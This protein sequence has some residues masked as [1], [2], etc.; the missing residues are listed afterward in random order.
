MSKKSNPN[1]NCVKQYVQQIKKKS[2]KLS[3]YDIFTFENKNNLLYFRGYA[4][5]Y[6]SPESFTPKLLNGFNIDPLKFD[7]SPLSSYPTLT[8]VQKTII[9]DFDKM[10]SYGTILYKAPCGAGKTKAALEFIYHFKLRTLIISCRNAVNDQWKKEINLTFPKLNVFTSKELK[11]SNSSSCKSSYDILILTPQ[12]ILKHI[13]TITK[14][15]LSIDLIIYDE[16]HSLT[17]LEFS[18]VLS[19]PFKL[20]LKN[21][22]Y[23]PY[24]IGLTASLPTEKP[25]IELLK[26]I[27]GLPKIIKNEKI[28]SIP[29]YYSDYRDTV[30]KRGNYDENYIRPSEHET[31]KLLLQKFNINNHLPSIDFKMIVITKLIESSIY[32]AILSAIMFQKDVLLIR[33]A[34]EYDYIIKYENIPD[35]YY[36][37]IE[38]ESEVN[39][40]NEMNEE[41]YSLETVLKDSSEQ[42]KP[43]IFK[44]KYQD[45][46]NE[47]AII[48]G[49]TDRLKEGF[50]CE[51]IVYGVCSN[52][53]WS[54]NSRIQ[55]L[56][57]I[58]RNSDKQELNEHKRI[59]LVCSGKIPND[60]IYVKMNKIPKKPEILYD[61]DLE[62]DLFNKENYI[63]KTFEDI[64]N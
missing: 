24:L 4:K 1:L 3:D 12:F 5:S 16:I 50:N 6:K 28:T 7:S 57:R 48:C 20:S 45:K 23:L 41:Q 43:F 56:G 62:K 64:F 36:T 51:N 19:L 60:L 42:D 14:F 21:N 25:C 49:T 33:A 30:Q 11:S 38:N 54:I 15:D 52:F 17:S 44:C 40:V 34:N 32:S 35:W 58:R 29:V 47:A 27:F 2:V 26:Q 39:E 59:F 37:E 10:K 22:T 61:I 9:S 8:N 18:K 63:N 55:I 53:V 46:L 13:N 31:I